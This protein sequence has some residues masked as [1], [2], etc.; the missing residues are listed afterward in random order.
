MNLER[1]N[2]SISLK[3]L[4]LIYKTKNTRIKEKIEKTKQK[5]KNIINN[6]K[7][8]LNDLKEENQNDS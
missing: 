5:K 1:L 2:F 8:K 3:I 4:F 6:N 7:Q